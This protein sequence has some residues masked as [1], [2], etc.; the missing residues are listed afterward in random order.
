LRLKPD[1]PN[2][3]ARMRGTG[4]WACVPAAL[5]LK[6]GSVGCNIDCISFT[7]GRASP[8]RCD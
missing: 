5:R 4:T 3:A 1:E 6:H 8:Q 7:L 2:S